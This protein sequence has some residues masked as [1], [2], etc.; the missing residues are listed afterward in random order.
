MTTSVS[1]NYP[2][3]VAGVLTRWM[4]NKGDNVD[5][6]QAIAEFEGK[7]DHECIH[8]EK[9]LI[10]PFNNLSLGFEFRV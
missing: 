10:Q 9:Y 3:S 8:C 4:V 1:I 7:L 6:G 5:E 2:H